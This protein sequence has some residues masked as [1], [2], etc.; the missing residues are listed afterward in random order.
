MTVLKLNG[1]TKNGPENYQVIPR[2]SLLV[3]N[4]MPNKQTTEKQINR[5]LTEVASPVSVTY[6][7]PET[8]QWKHGNQ[9]QLAQN[10]TTLSAIRNNYFDGLIVTGAPLEQ[11]KFSDIDFWQEFVQIRDWSKTHTRSQL[12]TCWGAQ[13][14]LYDDYAVPKID[15]EQKIFGIYDNQLKTTRLPRSF[16]MP[17]SRFSKVDA[18]DILK[19]PELE[20]LADN[21]ATGPFFIQSQIANSLYV[22]GHPEYQADTLINEYQRDK[23]LAHPTE[24]PANL[25]LRNPLASYVRWHNS[26]LNLYQTWMDKIEEEKYH[27]ERKQIQI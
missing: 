6:M 23:T 3:L 10:Y 16:L 20:I 13:A 12:F 14:A 24:K 25:S 4:L 26:S 5:L 18:K 7:Y 17:Q 9:R 8:H 19:V 21:Q 1:F 15:L 11:L 2:L 27:H 22:L